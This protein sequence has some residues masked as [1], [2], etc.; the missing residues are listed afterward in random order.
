[1]VIDAGETKLDIRQAAKNHELDWLGALKVVDGQVL[2][3]EYGSLRFLKPISEMSLYYASAGEARTYRFFRDR[4]QREWRQFFDPI[5]I[6]FSM[7]AKRIAADVTV[8]PLIMESE[9]NEIHSVVGTKLLPVDAG[10]REFRKRS[11]TGAS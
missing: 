2:S 5:A 4:Y 1:M 6:Q 9:Y 7:D 11:S 8:M 3:G 10:D